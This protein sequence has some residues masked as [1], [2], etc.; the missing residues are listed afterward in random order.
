MP[1]RQF[2]VYETTHLD[3]NLGH[4]TAS[5]D[6]K[7]PLHSDPASLDD[8]HPTGQKPIAT[9]SSTNPANTSIVEKIWGKPF[10]IEA[11]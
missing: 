4:I 2:L 10:V 7:S 11:S 5:Q 8:C 9:R 3:V 6:R 1:K